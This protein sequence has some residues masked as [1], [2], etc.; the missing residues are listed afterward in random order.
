MD[1]RFE[2]FKVLV[3]NLRLDNQ[4]S[5]LQT[6]PDF[7][8]YFQEIVEI[9][10]HHLVIGSH[11]VYGWMPTIL[12]LDL[13]HLDHTVE[14]LNDVKTGRLLTTEDLKYLKGK[15]NNSLVGVSKLLHFIA[16]QN[17]AI[18]DSWIYKAIFH[19]EPYN[20]RLGNVK[21]YIEYLELLKKLEKYR[22]YPQMHRIIEEKVGYQLSTLR[23]IEMV[24]FENSKSKR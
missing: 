6:Y 13:S 23:A 4:S 10:K 7:I 14:L 3:A 16:P 22:E 5:Y 17:Y 9:Q 2:E 18:W 12:R 20:Y 11:F 19:Q 15:I 21:V 8:Q 1:F 24:I